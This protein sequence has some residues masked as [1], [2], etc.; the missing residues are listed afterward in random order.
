MDTSHVGTH[1]RVERK[2]YFNRSELFAL[3]NKSSGVCGICGNPVAP[4]KAAIDHIMPIS[5][6]GSND[7]DNLQIAHVGCNNLKGNMTQGEYQ[8]Q[9]QRH[10]QHGSRTK[11]GGS[12]PLRVAATH[13]GISTEAVRM[14]V[15][16]GTLPSEKRD[17][18]VYV[19]VD[20]DQGEES[21]ARN[22]LDMVRDEWLMPLVDRIDAIYQD[23]LNEKDEL[24]VELRR[25]AEQA[26][27][28]RDALKVQQIAQERTGSTE[29][30]ER[31]E[32]EA[33]PDRA[34]WKFWE[35]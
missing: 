23:R 2:R 29:R 32:D 35:R 10:T 28:E 27:Q 13:L 18:R 14:R 1:S 17:G 20:T 34:W 19:Y 33:R 7:F 9:R 11:H 5:R 8:E 4:E 15:K 30:D 26:E 21:Y 31:H 6:G 3:W 16:R 12:Y 24:I 22:Q 25:R